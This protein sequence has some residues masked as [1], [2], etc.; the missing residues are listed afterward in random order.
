[1][2][3]E[4]VRGA[5]GAAGEIAY[6]PLVGDPFDPRHKLHGGLEDEI[7]AAGVRAG[8][9][10]R[11][12][13]RAAEAATAQDIFELAAAGDAD[14]GAVVEHIAA[15]LGS[16]I[17]TVCAILDPEL[18]VLGG[19]IGSSPLLLRPVRGAAAALVPLTA[20]IET[21]LL[22]DQAALR[23][24]IAVALHAARSQLIP[25]GGG[26]RRTELIR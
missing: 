14:A 26:V 20:R 25:Q 3:D 7:G 21:S 19:G 18:V 22:G 17:A 10:A 5:H 23:G 12:P 8:F 16:A 9:V 1:M 4:L 2:H 24:A 11:A 13:G 6:L 15:R